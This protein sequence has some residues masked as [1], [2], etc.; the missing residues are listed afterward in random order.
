MHTAS[1][2]NT[3][4]LD[5]PPLPYQLPTNFS[6]FIH[7]IGQFR[8][9]PLELSTDAKFLHKWVSNE[10]ARFW[11]MENDK[12]EAVINTYQKQLDNPYTWPYL[13]LFEDTPSFLVESYDPSYDILGQ[14]YPVQAGDIG[15]HFLIAPHEGT[16][17]HGFSQAVLHTILSFLF[18]IPSCQ[19]I[20]VEPDI[21]NEKIHPL[22]LA[23]GFHYTQHVVLPHKTAWLAF[24][25]RE[26]FH[27][28][29]PSE[30]I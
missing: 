26:D 24:C 17:I 25:Q 3:Y 13:G 6:R 29:T 12:P 20:V 16:T 9:R 22:N 1:D 2:H 30:S 8:L 23:V 15:M 5:T 4:T 11:G 18:S 21:R 28:P 19:R 14:H 10:R 7:G 27:Y